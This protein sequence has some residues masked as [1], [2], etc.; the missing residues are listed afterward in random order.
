MLVLHP[1]KSNKFNHNDIQ[2]CTRSGN[3][4]LV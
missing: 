3:E 2:A 1:Y 4:F